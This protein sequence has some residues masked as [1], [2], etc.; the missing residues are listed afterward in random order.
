MKKR[1][2]Q[3]LFTLWFQLDNN[4]W[5]YF[6]PISDSITILCN[7]NDPIDVPLK[8][9]GKLSISSGCKGYSSSVIL[10]TEEIKGSNSS[11]DGGD[12][13]SPVNFEYDCCEELSSK[14]NWSAVNLDTKFKP[15]LSHLDEL[16]VASFKSSEV[17]KMVK[18]EEW[19]QQHS[20]SHQTYSILVYICLLIL[21]IFIMY[22][23]YAWTTRKWNC[24]AKAIENVKESIIDS[25]VEK[26]GG[27]TIRVEVKNSNESLVISPE[28]L[29]LT[30][31]NKTEE[32]E[33]CGPSDPPSLRRSQR[34]RTSKSR[35]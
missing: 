3:I 19:K 10:M 15:M 2:L 5:L 20:A 16:K 25:F 13:L 30:Q 17:E 8:G 32:T 33:L 18:D 27:T 9:V 11:M 31:I 29:P 22:K 24:C 21:V 35:F 4:E 34:L 6:I 14:L 23:F 28:K 12:L 26:Q 1:I 7:N